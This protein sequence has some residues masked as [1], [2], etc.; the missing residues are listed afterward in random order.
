MCVFAFYEDFKYRAISWP[1]FVLIYAIEIIIIFYNGPNWTE[2]GSNLLFLVI[3]MAV[4]TIYIF[5]R[6]RKVSN[7]LKTHLGLG[8]ILF[9]I[10]LVPLFKSEYFQYFIITGSLFSLS[11]HLII[12]QFKHTQTVPF[13]GYLGLFLTIWIYCDFLFDSHL[14]IA[15]KN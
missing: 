11:L 3:I 1:V 14:L 15:F 7:V 2:I 4:L 12:N 13:A 6:Q 10:A 8:D 9:F 5:V